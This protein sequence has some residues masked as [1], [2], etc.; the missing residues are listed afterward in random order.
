M[1]GLY[2]ELKRRNV[3][4]VAVAYVGLAW[5]I[6]EAGVTIAVVFPIPNWANALLAFFLVLG[7]PLALFFAWA[8]ELTPDG[9]KREK[10]VDPAASVRRRTGRKLDVIIIAAL[11]L[12][13][14]YFAVDKFILS[15]TPP[16]E[17]TS[18]VVAKEEHQSIAVLP[19]VNMS[20]DPGNEYFSDGMSE[21]ILNLLA[22]IPD[23]KIIGRTSSFAFKGKNEDLRVIGQTLGVSTVLEG[24]VRKS[25]EK[26]RI[27]AQLIDVSDGSHIWSDTYDR[28][29]TDIFAVQ[30]D[31]A[32]AIIGALKIQIG[33]A[34]TRG[35]PTESPEA[36]TLFLRAR[37]LLDAQQ[38]KNAIELLLQAIELDANFAEAIELLA[39][40]YWQQG[41]T[42][43]PVSELQRLCHEAAANAIA[44]EPDLTFARALYKYSS[45]AI[46]DWR[47]AIE[48]LEKA[49]REQ[50]GNLTPLRPLIYEL[51]FR[52]YFRE[53]HRIALLF[54]AQDPLSPVA[55]YSLGESFVALGR[56]NEAL[57]SLQS[58]FE[59][60][61]AFAQW[62]LPEFELVLGRDEVAIGYYEADLRQAGVSD[63]AWVRELVT[64]S[65]KPATGQ[66][67]LSRRIP[68]IVASL[69]QEIAG[70]WQFTLDMWYLLFGFLDKYYEK[71]FAAGPSGGSWTD[72]DVDVWLG[73]IF[74]RVGFTAHPRYL[75]VAENLGMFEVWEQRGAP[76]FC[77]KVDDNW[78]CE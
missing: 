49:W 46:R 29:M 33:E 50:P 78:V 45:S 16:V 4:R 27:T 52:G 35:R 30:D 72:A 73:T 67:Y 60:D 15:S 26:I 42:S 74:R 54:I 7:F 2:D 28:R 66:A 63:T 23:L 69:P 18:P 41:G 21:E 5:L 1:A 9:I 62:F 39:Y 19:F 58:A 48:L 70:D 13:V 11:L 17:S 43:I 55:N 10:D 12:A 53:A 77:D 44:I 25:G 56:T 75:E 57:A 68:Q 31:V 38:G 59:L 14:G 34:P 61:N 20:D 40:S 37:V 76:D 22:N 36:Y 8:Y 51:T 3:I 47:D 64:A 32:A 65:R 24:S 71:I 6:F